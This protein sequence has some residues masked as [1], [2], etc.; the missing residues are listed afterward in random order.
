M[1]LNLHSGTKFMGWLRHCLYCNSNKAVAGF[2]SDIDECQLKPC[3]H[4][5]RNFVAGF[6]C[7][8]NKGYELNDDKRTCRGEIHLKHGNS[9]SL[10]EMFFQMFRQSHW[11]N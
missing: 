1:I 7:S 9:D 6:E 11:R 5:C 4:A 10:A 2:S 3:A 8:C